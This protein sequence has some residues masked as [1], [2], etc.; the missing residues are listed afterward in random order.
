MALP[1]F[2]SRSFVQR[3]RPR[4]PLHTDQG[5]RSCAAPDYDDPHWVLTADGQREIGDYRLTDHGE[6]ALRAM[7]G[8]L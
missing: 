3:T 5:S 7:A 2:D 6:D 1:D 8:E 4:T